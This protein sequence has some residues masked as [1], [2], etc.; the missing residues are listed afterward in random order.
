[1]NNKVKTILALVFVCVV[2]IGLVAYTQTT[3]EP[4]KTELSVTNELLK[5]SQTPFA[6]KYAALLD[7]DLDLSIAEG[8][9]VF[10]SK[11]GFDYIKFNGMNAPKNASIVVE[12]FDVKVKITK[13]NNIVT[14]QRL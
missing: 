2:T 9:M 10:I 12:F 13:R 8:K 7:S 3:K 11:A 1:M 4:T 14:V 5:L 6:Q